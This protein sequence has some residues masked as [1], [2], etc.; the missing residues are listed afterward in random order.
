MD[1]LN[2]WERTP[3]IL[4]RHNLAERYNLKIDQVNSWFKRKNSKQTQKQKLFEINED[5]KDS[6]NITCIQVCQVILISRKKFK[7]DY[8]YFLSIKR[9]FN[10]KF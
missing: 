8:Q 2:K 1:A 5:L 9:K 6:F 4:E 10:F 3:S 7:N